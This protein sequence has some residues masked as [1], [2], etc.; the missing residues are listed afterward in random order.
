M[1]GITIQKALDTIET[2]KDEISYLN[3]MIN[4]LKD[5]KDGDRERARHYLSLTLEAS[6]I[7]QRVIDDI[8]DNDLT[9]SD[10]TL[11][12]LTLGVSRKT[13]YTIIKDKFGIGREVY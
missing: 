12:K 3:K 5:V 2:Q 11:K 7:Y 10:I 13:R 4:T 6:P 8:V 9:P 1:K